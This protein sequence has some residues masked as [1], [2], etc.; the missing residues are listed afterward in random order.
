MDNMIRSGYAKNRNEMPSMW[1][2]VHGISQSTKIK[3]SFLF[4]K[5]QKYLEQKLTWILEKQKN[6]SISKKNHEQESCR[7]IEKQKPKVE[8]WKESGQGWL[9]F[10]LEER[11]SLFRLSWLRERTPLNNGKKDGSIF[12]ANGSNPP[13]KWDKVRQSYKKYI[14][15]PKYITTYQDRVGE[16]SI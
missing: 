5:L 15:T 9:H 11:S 13:Q 7:C 3:L 14:P 16:W 10:N 4:K 6:V 8:G 1:K 12:I 2:K